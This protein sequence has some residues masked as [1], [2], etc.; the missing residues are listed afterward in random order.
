MSCCTNPQD[1]G[2]IRA[3]EGIA[4]SVTADC[5]GVFTLSFE[6]NGAVI[7]RQ[8]L[9][10]GSGGFLTVPGNTFNEGSETTFSISTSAGV[11]LACYKV[12]VLAQE[13]NIYTDVEPWG[14]ITSSVVLTEDS[15]CA[16]AGGGAVWPI[17]GVITF[18]DINLLDN[19]TE[20]TIGALYN[21][22]VGIQTAVYQA[23][24]AGTSISGN[25]ITI[26]D[27]SLIGGN[28]IT[29]RVQISLAACGVSMNWR[30]YVACYSFLPVGVAVGNQLISNAI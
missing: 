27:K 14:T 2:C 23:L 13:S 7:T 30:N 6:H 16:P 1:L 4:T 19:G 3:C 20:I 22:N 25:V 9:S 5:A 11:E 28:S 24:T 12:K 26:N 17:T 10:N 29:F 8:L 21:N 15:P 18:N